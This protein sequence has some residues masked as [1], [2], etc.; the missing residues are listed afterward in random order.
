MITRRQ[1]LL[2]VIAISLS[3]LVPTA[4][5]KVRI[6]DGWLLGEGDR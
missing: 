1:L 3:G 2:A 4:S 6:H 5:A